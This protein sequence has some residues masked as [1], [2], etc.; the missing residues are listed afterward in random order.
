MTMTAA[1]ISTAGDTARRRAREV[2]SS[3][4]STKAR[5]RPVLALGS[6]SN[7]D[8]CMTL[9]GQTPPI[10][11]IQLYRIQ[12]NGA[13]AS[14]PGS[15]STS[16][17]ST[18]TLLVLTTNDSARIRSIT[19]SKCL[20]SAALMWTRA[21]ASPVTVQASTTSGYR[22][23]AVAISSGEVRPPQNSSTYAS[24][25]QPMAAGSTRAENPVMAPQARSRSTRRLTAGADSPTCAP[26]SA[27]VAR[28]SLT[29]A[30]TISLSSSS[31]A[32]TRYCPSPSGQAAADPPDAEPGQGRRERQVDRGLVP[33]EGPEPAAGLVDHHLPQVQPGDRGDALVVARVL[34]AG[35]G[36]R[37]EVGLPGPR[38]DLGRADPG[39]RQVRADADVQGA[40]AGRAAGAQF[41]HPVHVERRRE[42]K[43]RHQVEP[44]PELERGL[45]RGEDR[46]GDGHGGHGAADQ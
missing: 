8:M 9:A 30:A 14:V 46:Q 5:N 22:R 37:A 3:P 36:H 29:R 40:P 1:T 20:T 31:T 12:R 43:R 25:V 2:S 21:S 4:R 19:S 42:A 28:A 17:E 38:G 16:R 11:R 32:T 34:A 39:A 35:R 13:S 23:T 27:Y 10:Y 41:R 6:C 45:D 15:R 24:V 7:S 44:D 26:T 18:I 33:L